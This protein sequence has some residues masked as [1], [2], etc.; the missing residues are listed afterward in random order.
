[1]VLRAEFAFPRESKKALYYKPKKTFPQALDF[2]FGS[3]ILGLVTL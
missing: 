2:L 1:M 3:T